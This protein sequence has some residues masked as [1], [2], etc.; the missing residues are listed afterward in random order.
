ME[1]KFVIKGGKKL[2]GE[3][4]V[5]GAKNAAV[6]ILPATL[7]APAVYTIENLPK[8]DDVI[9]LLN[10]LKRLGAEVSFQDNT[11]VIDTTP[12][13]TGDVKIELTK[14]LRASYYF[15]GSLVARFSPAEVYLPGGCDIGNRP[16][17][18]HIKGFEALGAKLVAEYGVLR[19]TRERLKGS[20]IYLDQVSVGATINIMLAAVGAVGQTVIANAAK[21][22]HV[23]DVANFLNMMGA[24]VKGAG[25]D[26]IRIQG[27]RR[28]HGCTYA[29]IPDQIEA[30]T[31]MIAAAATGGDVVINNI[32]PIHLEA[33]SAKLMESG[34]K[35][36]EGDDGRDFFIRVTSDGTHRGVNIKTLPYPGFPTDLQQPMMAFLS[37]AQGNSYIVENIFEKR[38]NHVPE[39]QRMG[40]NIHLNSRTAMIEGVPKLSGAT[41]CATDLR[42]GA[43]MIVAALMAEGMS[44]L[45]N[46]EY[47][48]RGY[49]YI[50]QKLRALGADI[51]RVEDGR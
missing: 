27:G 33:I 23:V 2:K 20:D 35:V 37:T 16:I 44:A 40:A 45:R 4:S 46:I 12:V 30:G 22:P 13:A 25:T 14:R 29:I 38:F 1:E 11:A 36:V 7:L 48:D 15:L 43:A 49:E 26:V 9:I 18:L 50:E 39:L 41:L 32:I 6:A 3:V 31:F 28:L 10:I 42:A 21:E 5:G 51:R 17:D 47:I 19:A 24:N 8:I 34:V